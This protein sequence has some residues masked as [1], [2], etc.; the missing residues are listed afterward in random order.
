MLTDKFYIFLV[1]HT[2]KFYTK[3]YLIVRVIGAGGILKFGK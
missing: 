3:V 1:K 2:L